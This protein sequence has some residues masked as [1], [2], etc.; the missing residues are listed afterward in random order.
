M[1]GRAAIQK[2]WIFREIATVQDP[3]IIDLYE[4]A[5]TFTANLEKY[6]P[7]EFYETRARRYW[8]FYLD[9]FFFGHGLKSKITN[10]SKRE[11]QLAHLS[12]YF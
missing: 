2:P 6:Q 4:I 9:N 11:E 5:E 7:K 8:A 10:T 1:I 3:L 12:T